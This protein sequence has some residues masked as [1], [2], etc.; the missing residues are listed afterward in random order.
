[1]VK[2]D[3]IKAISG[4]IKVVTNYNAVSRIQYVIKNHKFRLK[5]VFLYQSFLVL[6][7][8]SV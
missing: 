4:I 5:V 7:V 1:M 6:I 8:K 2:K 3:N